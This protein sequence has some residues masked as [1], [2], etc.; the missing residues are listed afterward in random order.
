MLILN[1]LGSTNFKNDLIKSA[2]FFLETFGK[3]KARQG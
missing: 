3:M 1:D 2:F